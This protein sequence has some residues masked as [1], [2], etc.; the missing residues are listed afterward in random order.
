MVQAWSSPLQVPGLTNVRNTCSP[1]APGLSAP[2]VNALL[3]LEKLGTLVTIK[4]RP[5]VLKSSVSLLPA[6]DI[7]LCVMK[8]IEHEIWKSLHVPSH[9]LPVY[10]WPLS[11][12]CFLRKTVPCHVKAMPL[13]V[14]L[15]PACA[16]SVVLSCASGLSPFLMLPFL[17]PV[18]ILKPF[19]LSASRSLPLVP[20]FSSYTQSFS[21]SYRSD[22]H[23]ETSAPS[24]PAAVFLCLHPGPG[25]SHSSPRP[26]PR[27]LAAPCTFRS[28]SY[29][30]SC[31]V[32]F[33]PFPRDLFSEAVPP[34]PLGF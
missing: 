22:S 18:D 12:L 34:W 33:D 9:C 27:S 10:P 17:Q 21:S 11:L 24:Q 28:S 32:V 23:R 29:W 26:P 6:G 5:P 3:V 4:K 1:A 30:P 16:S 15:P 7:A 25:P 13:P 20:S 2:P 31:F 8:K 14:L 19:S